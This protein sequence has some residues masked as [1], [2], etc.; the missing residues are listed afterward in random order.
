LAAQSQEPKNN[1][2]VNAATEQMSRL[3]QLVPWVSGW[4]L[5]PCYRGAKDI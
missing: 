1:V 3:Y 4:Y 2:A 5:S